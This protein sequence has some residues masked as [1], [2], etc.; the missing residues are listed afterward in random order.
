MQHM[1]RFLS[2][3]LVMALVL[4]CLPAMALAADSTPALPTAT[5][6]E[7]SKDD[8]TFAMN[9]KVDSI[10]EEQLSYYGSW[11]ADFELTVNKTVTFNNDG[12]A[13]GWLA[14]QYDSY[15]SDW[16]TVPYGKYAPVTLEAGETLKIMAFAAEYMS[17]PGLKYTFKEVYEDVKDF[18]C[19]VYF[20]DEFLLAN[21]DL[22]VKLELKMYNPE[23]E[24]ESYLVGETYTYSNPVAAQNTATNK[25]YDTVSAAMMD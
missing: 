12:S 23:N 1:K 11:Y 5:V 8:L 13:D 14:G 6:A 10:T 15:S 9:F 24:A 16:Y 4:S 25:A 20:D 17:E 22:E 21:P 3:A 2:L 7:I 19:G 18:D